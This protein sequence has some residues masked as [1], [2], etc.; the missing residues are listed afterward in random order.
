MWEELL[1]DVSIIKWGVVCIAASMWGVSV[2]FLLK[3]LPTWWNSHKKNKR[4]EQMRK[5]LAGAVRPRR[6]RGPSQWD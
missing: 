4:L 2:Y 3:E 1:R 5:D 6:P